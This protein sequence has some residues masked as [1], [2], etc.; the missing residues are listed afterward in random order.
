MNPTTTHDMQRTPASTAVEGATSG[1]TDNAHWYAIWTRSRHEQLVRNQLVR[2]DIEAFL[3]TVTRWSRWKDRRKR[4]EWPLF[5]SY[6]FAR[7]DAANRLPVLSCTGVVNIVSVEGQPAAVPDAEVDSLRVLVTNAVSYDACPLLR[8]GE[9]VKVNAGPLFGVVGRLLRKDRR[10]A[11]VVLSV[12]LIGQA[13]R[14]EV[15]AADIGP[16]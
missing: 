7:F 6:C 5:P 15:D 12:D 11:S 14:V 4:I 13:V 8:E 2:K 10:R 3:P 9:L 16:A 1:A